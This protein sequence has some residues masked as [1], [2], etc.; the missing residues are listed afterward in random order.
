MTTRERLLQ[1]AGELLWRYG[2]ESTS[3]AMVM[4]GSGV[5]KG[6]LY[7]HFPSKRALAA[8]V[9][10]SAREALEEGAAQ[11]LRDLGRRPIER[12]RAWLDM[13]RDG[14]RGCRLG[15]FAG[16]ESL[17][18]DPELRRPIA[19]YFRSLEGMIADLI[20]EA[21]GGAT[22]EQPTSADLAAM[23]SA[24]VQGGYTLSRVHADPRKMAQA[25]GC[26]LACLERVLGEA[27]T[28]AENGAQEG[29]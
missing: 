20:D 16:E 18:R 9:I 7:H 26:A 21:R 11:T 19:E 25:T 14:E 17:I 27:D 4:T 29:T 13:P 23:L 2:Y 28:T 12:L 15:R 8:A 3:P 10:E 5:G 1:T 22:G 24:V 6:S